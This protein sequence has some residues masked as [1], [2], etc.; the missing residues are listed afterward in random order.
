M[1]SVLASMR[2]P[3]LSICA[4]SS[5]S[6]TYTY[7]FTDAERPVQRRRDERSRLTVLCNG[8]FKINPPSAEG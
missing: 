3:K 8:L 5:G 6:T 4:T 1:V 7:L 2:A